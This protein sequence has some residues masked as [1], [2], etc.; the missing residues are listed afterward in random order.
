MN[1]IK[2]LE[3]ILKTDVLIEVQAEIDALEKLIAK[4]TSTDLENELE[5]M[6]D[7][8]KF[9]NEVLALIEKGKLTQ[10]EATNILLDLEDMRADDED[11]I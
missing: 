11:E 4:K 7:I 8:K 3:K 2:E 10:E 9:Y 1:K 5:Y 6:L